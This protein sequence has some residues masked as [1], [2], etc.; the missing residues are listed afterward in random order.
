MCD[1]I[2]LLRIPKAFPQT[3]V[4]I[5]LVKIPDCKRIK[6]KLMGESIVAYLIFACL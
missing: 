4:Q 5:G 2:S 3:I 1:V 6:H